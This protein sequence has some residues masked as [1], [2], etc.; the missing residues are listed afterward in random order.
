MSNVYLIEC[1]YEYETTSILFVTDTLVKA[2][3]KLAEMTA[4]A[5]E[6]FAEY[7]AYSIVEHVLDTSH[8]ES[9]LT[10]G[11]EGIT[12]D[13]SDELFSSDFNL[14]VDEVNEAYLKHIASD[15]DIFGHV[16]RNGENVY[17]KPNM[18]DVLFYMNRFGV[19]YDT[20]VRWHKELSEREKNS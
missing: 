8:R 6:H 2:V 17:F 9:V 11:G 3:R 20:A 15:A 7:R 14:S 13:F 4:E 5:G 18:A 16:D 10:T 1:E 19:A 12:Y